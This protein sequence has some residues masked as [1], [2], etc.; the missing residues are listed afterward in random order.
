ME[1]SSPYA[2]WSELNRT[3]APL[4]VGDVLET[5][6]G[7]L[8]IVKYVG[9]EDAYWVLPEAKPAVEPAALEAAG[10]GRPDGEASLG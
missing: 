5:E 9:V 3:D 7:E 4:R 10:G 2:A 8:R 6:A 1:A